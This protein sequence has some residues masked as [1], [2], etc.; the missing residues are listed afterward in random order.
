MKIARKREREREMKRE[1]HKSQVSRALLFLGSLTTTTIPDF[2]NLNQ[3][4]RFNIFSQEILNKRIPLPHIIL[5]KVLTVRQPNKTL[6]HHIHIRS[7]RENFLSFFL[8][9]FQP[10]NIKNKF[11][12]SHPKIYKSIHNLFCSRQH[13]KKVKEKVQLESTMIFDDKK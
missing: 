1:S 2:L 11:K 10:T 8:R 5:L 4:K 7:D 12:W 6:F 9:F 3:K 13:L